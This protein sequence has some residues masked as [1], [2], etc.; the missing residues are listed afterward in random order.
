VPFTVRVALWTD[1]A[2]KNRYFAIPPGTTIGF[3]ESGA[4]D[5]PVGTIFMKEFYIERVVGD[6]STTLVMETRF[7]VRSASKW[8]GYSYRWN[9]DGADGVL[10]DTSATGTYAV[11]D[12]GVSIEHQHY[13]PTRSECLRCHPREAG[14]AIGTQ[15]LQM[16]GDFDYGGVVDN[17]IRALNHAG[18]FDRDV[19]GS[20]AT[21]AALPSPTDTSLSLEVRARAILHANCAHCHQPLG[22]ATSALVRDLRYGTP[23]GEAAICP[24]VVPGNPDA[25]NLWMQ[26]AG[27]TMPPIAVFTLD[28]RAEVVRE[29]IAEMASCP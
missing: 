1:G 26:T 28:P 13:F 9:D 24:Q 5:F 10:L 11:V 29:W 22:T 27:V 7:F 14:S 17:Q 21:F 8:R 4:W 16:N 3:T 18:Y 23:L 25:S 19:S 12:N 15:T 6:P 2:G 20:L